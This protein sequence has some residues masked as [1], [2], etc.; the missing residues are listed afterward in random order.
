M[1][2]KAK[3]IWIDKGIYPNLQESCISAFS[4]D[5]KKYSFGVAAFKKEYVFDK[6]VKCAE[7]E[8]FGDT[9]YYLWQNKKFI[10][11]GPCPSCGDFIMP[12][13]Y[14]DHFY[15]DV[16][17]YNIEFYGR[18]QLTPTVERDNSNGKGCFIMEAHL[19][20]EDQ[21]EGWVWTD[22]TW[23]ARRE[24]EFISPWYMDYTK[25]RDPWKNAVLTECVWNLTESQIKTVQEEIVDSRVFTV[26]A[27]EQK[28]FAVQLNKIYSAYSVLNIKANGSYRIEL[29]TSEKKAVSKRRHLIIGNADECYRSNEYYSVGEYKIC[30]DN[31][32][33]YDMEIVSE[34]IFVCYPSEERGFFECSDNILNRIYDLGKW[35][36]KICR[37]SLELDSPVHQENLLC[38]G[39]YIIESLVNY[40]TTGDYSLTRFDIIRMGRYLETT[41]G[42]M[43]NGTY[44]LLWIKW[45]YEYYAHTGDKDIFGEV[46]KGMEAVLKRYKGMENEE[47]LLEEVDGYSFIDWTYIDGYSMYAPPRVLGETVSNAYYYNL[48]KTVSNIYFIMEYTEKAIFYEAKANKFKEIFNK[49]F[50][51]KEKGIYFDGLNAVSQCNSWIPENSE[52]RYYTRYSNI[53]AVLFELCDKSAA[54]NILE[55]VM[56]PENLEGIQPYFMHYLL[57]ALSKNGLFEKYGLELL[58]KWERLVL[59]CE[60]GMHEV[61]IEFDGYT[62]DYSHG[63]G[64]TPTYQLPSKLLGINILEPGFKKIEINPRLYGL[65]WA[66][67]IVPTPYGNIECHMEE[68]KEIQL[69]IPKEIEVVRL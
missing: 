50:Y 26:H 58:R 63:W 14:T 23:L 8:I 33:G 15:V 62:T 32:S 60:K 31:K 44:A 35:T 43:Y 34:V 54:I 55:W 46:Q 16:N 20:F 61:W 2:N 13:Q 67:I 66:N 65:K 11:T 69:I 45:L 19:I 24:R 52:V 17:D 37:Q 1:I 42:Y 28:E 36:V 48:L 27:N 30:V 41:R 49:M 6:R 10:G 39:D 22:E 64:A 21:S 29:I 68:G 18:V 47:G 40:Y 9:R 57:E 7:I 51:E 3:F 12:Y 4:P 5:R 38:T 25:K 59:E 53:V 56:K